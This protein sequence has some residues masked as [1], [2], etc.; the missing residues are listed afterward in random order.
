M[1]EYF[2]VATSIEA[3]LKVKGSRFI[4]LLCAVKTR[5]EAE[6]HLAAR[7]RQYHDATHHC[8]GY[9]IG[10]DDHLVFKSSDAGEPAG[11]AGRPI[12]QALEKMNLTNTLAIVTRYFGGTKLGTG[13]LARAY[14]AATTAAI[15]RAHLVPI[16]SKQTL[17]L[18]YA[19]PQSAV[20]QRILHQLEAETID[21]V[22]GVEVEHTVALRASRLEEAQRLLR[23]SGAGKIVVELVLQQQK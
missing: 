4:A 23:E 13:G 2:S 6:G 20:V 5:Q 7:A 11:T 17:R 8:Y 16:F 15:E 18:R 21:E 3:E 10:F 1:N 14:R 22:F 19:Y 12:L 9:R